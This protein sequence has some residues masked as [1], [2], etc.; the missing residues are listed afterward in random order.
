MEDEEK[1][2]INDFYDYRYLSACEAA[3]RIF[4]FDI[5]HRFP[6][7][8]RLPFHYPDEQT[9]VFDPSKSIDYQVEKASLNTTKFLEWMETNKTDEFA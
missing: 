6:A 7:V 9:V 2:E 4:K 5:H 1:D 8:E 3:W